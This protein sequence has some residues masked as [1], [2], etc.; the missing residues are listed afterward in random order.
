MTDFQMHYIVFIFY[1]KTLF[2]TAQV[3]GCRGIVI[4]MSLLFMTRKS[5]KQT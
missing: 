3:N 5:Q 1:L 4:F 2:M